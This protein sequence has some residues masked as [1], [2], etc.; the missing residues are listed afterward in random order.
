MTVKCLR[1]KRVGVEMTTD[2]RYQQNSGRWKVGWRCIT[3]WWS[4]RKRKS[5]LEER[6]AP[7]ICPSSFRGTWMMSACYIPITFKSSYWFLANNPLRVGII[8]STFNYRKPVAQ[9]KLTTLYKVTV[10]EWQSWGL[11]S[12]WDWSPNLLSLALLPVVT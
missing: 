4:Q 10:N 9:K 6:E 1:P 7:Q 5:A 3:I 12:A 2:D 11:H 8:S